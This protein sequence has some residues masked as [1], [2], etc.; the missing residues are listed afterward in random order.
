MSELQVY[1]L[2]FQSLLFYTKMYEI[3][4]IS[5]VGVTIYAERQRIFAFY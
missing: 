3:R 5:I 1:F 2:Y 4:P